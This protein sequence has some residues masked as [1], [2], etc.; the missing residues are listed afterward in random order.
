MKERRVITFSCL[1]KTKRPKSE[2]GRFEGPPGAK[3]ARFGYLRSLE[4]IWYIPGRRN[5]ERKQME[6]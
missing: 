6:K 5:E 3:L 2:A 4:P 1:R